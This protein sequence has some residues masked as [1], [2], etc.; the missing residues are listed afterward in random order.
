MID[1]KW[2]VVEAISELQE[3]G[4]VKLFKLKESG[5][6]LLPTAGHRQYRTSQI[7]MLIQIAS[8]SC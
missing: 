1:L 2:E 7:L 8:V 4:K 3:E 6:M 5:P